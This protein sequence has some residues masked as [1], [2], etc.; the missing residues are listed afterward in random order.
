MVG[1]EKVIKEEVILTAEPEKLP[2]ALI[3][4]TVWENTELSLPL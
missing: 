3:L 4:T 1:R 2:W